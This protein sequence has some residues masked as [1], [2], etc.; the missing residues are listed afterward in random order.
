M[1][2]KKLIHNV[3]KYAS[4][5]AW[6]RV[7]LARLKERPTALDYI[8]IIFDDFIELHG[9]RSFSDDQSIVCGI[10][11]LDNKSVTVIAQQKGKNLK[12]NIKRNFG[13]P[14]PEGYRKALRI[15]KQAEKF[16]RPVVCFIDTPGAFCGID[17]EERGQG[18][19]I[20]RNLLEMSR[21]K[22]ITLSIVIGEGG[23]GGALALGVADRVIMLENSIYSILSPE[24]FASILWKDA[25]KAKEA[26]EV[27][28]IT[29]E[30]LKGFNIIDKIIKEPT[31]GAHK[32]LNKMAETIKEN[33]INEIEILKEYPLDVL[34]DKRY[35]KFRNMGVFSE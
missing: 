18:E 22:T 12:D 10:G 32:N 30:D 35:N 23:S 3:K 7:T 34:L 1:E 33:I 13:M 4:K 5:N 15:M 27:M 31:G 19:A 9:D 24:G 28:K 6:Q 16:K 29:A 2:D 8:N 17:A 25:S 26:A 20:A 21:L 14:K 11:L